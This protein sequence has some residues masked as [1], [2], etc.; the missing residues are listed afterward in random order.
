MFVAHMQG[1]A[2]ARGK[3]RHA[4][5]ARFPKDIALKLEHTSGSE[6]TP[7]E[8]A[9]RKKYAVQV[10][11]EPSKFTERVKI[12]LRGE[13]LRDRG[14]LTLAS[15]AW[16]SYRQQA[17]SGA[18]RRQGCQANLCAS[19]Q[20]GA[21]DKALGQQHTDVPSRVLASLMI[22]KTRV[23]SGG[24]VGAPQCIPLRTCAETEQHERTF[25]QFY[26]QRT[27]DHASRKACLPAKARCSGI[28]AASNEQQFSQ[29]CRPGEATV[30]NL[31]G[32]SG[33]QETRDARKLCGLC[34]RS[35]LY[36]S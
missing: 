7:T 22:N 16:Q 28:N 1:R 32:P 34:S 20:S 31:I 8:R 26:L 14:G 33:N 10:N 29:E 19:E 6:R 5:T 13:T 12:A 23:G 30:S 27:T 24:D 3:R 9:S 21:D 2:H 15:T 25:S 17:T 18:R 36:D 4:V 11:I 35:R